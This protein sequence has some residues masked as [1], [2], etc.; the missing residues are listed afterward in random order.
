MS[1][2]LFVGT[3]DAFGAGGRRQSA[4]LLRGQRGTQGAMGSPAPA[5]RRVFVF[6]DALGPL[7]VAD[8]PPGAAATWGRG[9]ALPPAPQRA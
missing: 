6:G 3:S 9:P 1:E 8:A 5:G 7:A 2:V 4:I